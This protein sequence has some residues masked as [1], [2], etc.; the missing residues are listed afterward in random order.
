MA[1]DEVQRRMFLRLAGAGAS[2][3]ALGRQA[4]AAESAAPSQPD[5]DYVEIVGVAGINSSLVQL[6]DGSLL[7][8]D[9]RRS[10]DAGHT[11]SEAQSFGDGVSGAGIMRL[12]SGKL[13]LVSP[14]GYAAGQMH[15]SGDEGKSWT[16]AG[17]IKTPGGPIYELGD[18]MI[19]L[20]SGRLLYCWDYN[21]AG[22]HPGLEYE[23]VTARGTWKGVSY[24]VEGHGHLP[25]YFAA[26]FSWSDDEGKSWTY[27]TWTNMPNVLMGWFDEAGVPNGNSGITPCGESSIVQTQ[28]GRVLIFGRS[29]VGRIVHSYSSDHGERWLPLLPTDLA[30]SNSPPRLRRIPGTGDLL[31]IWNQVSG[32]EIRDGFRRGR[33]SSAISKDNGQTWENFKTIEAC[34]GMSDAE[35]VDPDAAIKPVLAR[36]DVGELP[37]GYAYYHYANICFADDRVYLMYA[38][39]YPQI[40]VAEQLLHQQ[41]QVLRIYPLQWFYA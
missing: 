13:A 35:R 36:Q 38:R 11:W 21:M 20:E 6:K 28:D 41:E 4:W 2:V 18:T 10:T 31:C 25:E 3:A 23:T 33:L 1:S 37:D 22:N 7:S 15:L 32:D 34:E 24:D 5:R 14:V 19:Q 26:G 9:G 30:A 12:Q 40:G 17:P 39:G 8:S 16:L 29:T 27:G